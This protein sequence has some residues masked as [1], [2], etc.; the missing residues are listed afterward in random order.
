MLLIATGSKCL[1][2]NSMKQRVNWNYSLTNR[3]GDT[4]DKTNENDPLSL[5]FLSVCILL[6]V[7]YCGS[8]L[9]TLYWTANSSALQQKTVSSK[10]KRSLPVVSAYSQCLCFDNFLHTF[11]YKHIYIYTYIM[12]YNYSHPIFFYFL[13]IYTHSLLPP[14]PQIPFSC[15]SFFFLWI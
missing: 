1:Q 12:H 5:P 3:T 7:C 14:P 9:A 4:E 8:Y 10:R 2:H 11:T 13:P 15:S 6:C